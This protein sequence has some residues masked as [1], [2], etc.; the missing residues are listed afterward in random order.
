MPNIV[1]C[2]IASMLSRQQ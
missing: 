1:N 2:R